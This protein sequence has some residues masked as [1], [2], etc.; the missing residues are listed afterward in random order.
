MVRTDPLSLIIFSNLLK[1]QTFAYYIPLIYLWAILIIPA[2][3][4]VDE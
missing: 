2:K 3:G 4:G 1:Y